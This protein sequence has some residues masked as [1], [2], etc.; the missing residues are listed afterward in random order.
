M[1]ETVSAA[2]QELRRFRDVAAE[3][4]GTLIRRAAALEGA[5]GWFARSGSAGAGRLPSDLGVR[6]RMHSHGLAALAAFTGH[7]ADAFASVAAGPVVVAEQR[8]ILDWL[9]DRWGDTGAQAPEYPDE[10]PGLVPGDNGCPAVSMPTWFGLGRD[11]GEREVFDEPLWVALQT[12]CD[13]VAEGRTES[14][15]LVDGDGVL[16]RLGPEVVA[17][18]RRPRPAP[19][20][21]P[22]DPPAPPVRVVPLAPT[23]SPVWERLEHYR[24]RT[25]TNGGRGRKLRFYEWDYTHG[26]IEVY[27]RNGD[28]LGTAD[29]ISGD[30]DHGA[31]VP[32]RT[33]GD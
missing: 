6:V 29:P 12:D 7:V 28:H 19:G 1:G 2:P 10:W 16:V 11:R 26:H 3:A 33:L 5:I 4:S 30:V 8:R 31:A 14:R 20:P 18:R 27:D 25:R 9:L 32:G 17:A 21:R 22:G 15:V 13:P 24:G 23:E